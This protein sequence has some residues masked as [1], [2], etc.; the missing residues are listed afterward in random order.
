MRCH[1]V[2]WPCVSIA[3]VLR[4]FQTSCSLNCCQLCVDK[5]ISLQIY[6]TDVGVR[7]LSRHVT[8]IL[9]TISSVHRDSPRKD[10][11]LLELRFFRLGFSSAINACLSTPFFLIAVPVCCAS[12]SLYFNRITILSWGRLWVFRVLCCYLVY[13]RDIAQFSP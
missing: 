5:K 7:S 3:R 13:W 1:T 8:I 10:T 2:K 12:G 4:F 6:R 11:S 9:L